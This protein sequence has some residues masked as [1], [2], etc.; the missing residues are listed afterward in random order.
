[1]L[2]LLFLDASALV[3]RYVG[4]AGSDA[5]ARLLVDA[6]GAISRYS[7]VEC[8][9][10]ISRRWREGHLDRARRDRALTELSH[11]AARLRIVELSG[12]VVTRAQGLLRRHPLRAGDATQLASGL[13]LAERLGRAVPFVCFDRLLCEAARAEGLDVLP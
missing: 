10:A 12:G 8:A 11:D 7:L 1:M 5:V 9:S 6:E 13:L 3:K 4:E 2:R